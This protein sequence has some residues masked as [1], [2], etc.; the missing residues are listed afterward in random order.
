MALSHAVTRLSFA[1]FAAIALVVGACA[2]AAP[3]ATAGS[4]GPI[5]SGGAAASGGA[6]VTIVAENLAYTTPNV[7][8]PA[9]KPFTILFQNKDQS[10]LHDVDILAADGSILFD[11]L[12]NIG[13][14]TTTY[15]VPALPAGTYKFHCAVHPEV[16]NGTLKAG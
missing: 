11:G 5:G 9:G 14:A 1:G 8:A 3:A 10:S 15:N 6:D 12:Y 16:M 2:G 13:P 7:S 4:G